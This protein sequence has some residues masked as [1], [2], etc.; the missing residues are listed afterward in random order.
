MDIVG[1][2]SAEEVISFHSTLT[3]CSKSKVDRILKPIYK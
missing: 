2:A 1:G 3:A